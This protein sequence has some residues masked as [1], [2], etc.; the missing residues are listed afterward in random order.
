[1][2]PRPGDRHRRTHTYV[3]TP[4][5]LDRMAP[6]K[7]R[8]HRVAYVLEWG[9]DDYSTALVVWVGR[10]CPERSVGEILSDLAH[11]LD[12]AEV[13]GPSGGPAR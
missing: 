2:I 12:V 11:D 7:I 6:E 4:E 9:E 10:K 8:E 13:D 1:M 3:L 5:E